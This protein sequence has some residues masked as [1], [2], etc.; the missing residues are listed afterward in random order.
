MDFTLR[1]ISVDSRF[2]AY[3][4]DVLT[5]GGRLAARIATCLADWAGPA[6]VLLPQDVER[7]PSNFKEGGLTIKGD[8]ISALADLLSVETTLHQKTI[9]VEQGLARRGDAFIEKLDRQPFYFED[10]V[11]DIVDTRSLNRD[12][13][14]EALSECFTFGSSAFFVPRDLIKHDAANSI[15]NM[16]EAVSSIVAIC[17]GIYDGE[18]SFIWFK[19]RRPGPI[20]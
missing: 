14:E 20:A 16:D 13:I 1:Q 18:T 19:N 10:S 11:V 4:E 15:I 5:V 8:A 12:E 6:L 17:S 9:L 7:Y 3:A 2:T